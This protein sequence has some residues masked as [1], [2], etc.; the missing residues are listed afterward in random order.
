MSS[1]ALASIIA[2]I[3]GVLG[4]LLITRFDDV[5]TVFRKAPR[6]ISGTWEGQ[7]F[8]ISYSSNI[9]NEPPLIEH[10]PT[11]LDKY[12]VTVKQRGT[13]FTAIMKETE[14]FQL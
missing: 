12:I 6:D 14:T 10:E 5:M 2:A 13:K 3:I 9:V 8:E 7:S 11:L 1:E 4:T